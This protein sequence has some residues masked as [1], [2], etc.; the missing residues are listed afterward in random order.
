MFEALA[1][2]FSGTAWP[3]ALVGFVAIGFFVTQPTVP[4][5]TIEYHRFELS[6]T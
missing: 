3:Y 6:A 5:G 2:A 4:A 1:N